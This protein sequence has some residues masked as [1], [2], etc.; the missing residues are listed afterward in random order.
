MPG[1]SNCFINMALKATRGQG[2]TWKKL[3][4]GCLY[5]TYMDPPAINSSAWRQWEAWN[6]CWQPDL[7]S[8]WLFLSVLSL[9][10]S[11]G[12]CPKKKPK[13]PQAAALFLLPI[14]SSF[15]KLLIW[16]VKVSLVA[17]TFSIHLVQ[18]SFCP[19]VQEPYAS[20]SHGCFVAVVAV[21]PFT[22]LWSQFG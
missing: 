2:S 12:T 9:S 8:N 3:M 7:S 5:D 1:K 19:V 17:S 13:K 10:P 11:S 18:R 15:D 22:A 6:D 21:V 20:L 4:S 14:S 16:Q